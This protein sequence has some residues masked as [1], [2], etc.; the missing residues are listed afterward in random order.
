M[1]MLFTYDSKTV[2]TDANETLFLDI[3]E[4]WQQTFYDNHEPLCANQLFINSLGM[5]QLR[6]CFQLDETH[7][8]GMDLIDGEADVETNM[9]MDVTTTQLVYAIASSIKE[10]DPLYLFRDESF[11][12]GQAMLKWAPMND[13]DGREPRFIS[14]DPIAEKKKER[15]VVG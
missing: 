10:E 14:D 5:N 15:M 1:Q 11:P 9:K 3:L 6:R 7:S 8:F 2:E 12:D 4:Q 13:G